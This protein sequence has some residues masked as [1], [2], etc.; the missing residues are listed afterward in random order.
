MST[1]NS[2]HTSRP[3]FLLVAAEASADLH[4]ARVIE[5]LRARIPEARFIGIG[6]DACARAGAELIAEARSLSVMG[7][8]DVLFALPRILGIMRRLLKVASSQHIDA[9][10]LID[11]PDFNLRVARKLHALDIPVTYFI[12]PKLWATREGR[13]AQVRRYVNRMLVIFPFEVD[14]YAARGVQ[15]EYVGNPVVEQMADRYDRA[16][17]RALLGISPE[18]KVVAML[19]GSRGGEIDRLAPALGQ[20][21]QTL[22]ASDGVSVYIPRAPTIQRERLVSALGGE[23]NIQLVDGHARELLAAADAAVVAAGTATLEAAMV[24]VP[25]LMVYKVS[26]FSALIYRLIL[27]IGHLSL[28]NIIAQRPVIQELWQN[29]VQSPAIVAATRTL[30]QGQG[31]EDMLAAY[32][33]IRSQL[34][35]RDTAARV[36]SVL[37]EEAKRKRSPSATS[38]AKTLTS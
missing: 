26:W 16:S 14:Y 32:T 35:R 38:S 33:E 29:A 5:A 28:I 20:A 6:G 1:A 3:V 19:P 25:T 27:R 7:F 30:L 31:R 22:H 17:S 15:A 9:A 36:A 18:A 2:P 23:N 10:L 21:A 8:S 13:V 11:A 4:G 37:I 34:G 12:S 24:G